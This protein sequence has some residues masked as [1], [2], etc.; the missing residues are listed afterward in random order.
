MQ[1]IYNQMLVNNLD[2][3]KMCLGI[4]AYQNKATGGVCLVK[5]HFEVICLIE[6]ALA[7]SYTY[8]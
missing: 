7:T 2:N 3:E 4:S 1:Q 5:L 8:R 6:N